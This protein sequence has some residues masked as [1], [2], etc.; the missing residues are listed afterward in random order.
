[1][2]REKVGA[3]TF[4]ALFAGYWL[5]ATQIE[6]YPGEELDVVTAR[7]FPMG[8]GAMGAIISALILFLPSREAEA[9]LKLADLDWRR[10][11]I[12]IVLMATFGLLL[13]PAGFF[14]AT[15]LF[16]AG[17]YYTL[18]E[19]RPLVLTGASIGV[20]AVFEF[21]LVGLLGIF[22]QDPFLTLIGLAP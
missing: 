17:G 6:L 2:T 3:L 21:I 19:R 22:L 15:S 14:V 18:G 10:L 13:R 4:F 12:L 8:V 5:V 9:P 11:L 1:M 16:L 7:T 20:A